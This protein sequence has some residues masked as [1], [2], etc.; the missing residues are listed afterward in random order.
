[1]SLRSWLLPVSWR[2][3]P[4][5]S[6]LAVACTVLAAVAVVRLLWFS[7]KTVPF[8]YPLEYVEGP[9][10]E[11][12]LTF[13]EFGDVYKTDFSR[14]PYVVALYPPLFT[15]L[16]VPL[17]WSFG[18]AFW[19]GR[20]ISLASAILAGLFVGLIIRTFTRSTPAALLGAAF[21][22]SFKSVAWWALISR[23]DVLAL[24]LSC[25]ALFVVARWR[26]EKQWLAVILLA[27]AIFTR[28]TYLLAAPLA[29]LNWLYM[30]RGPLV[31]MRFL[32]RLSIAVV[33]PFAGLMLWTKGAFWTHLISVHLTTPI[34]WSGVPPAILGG[35]G[36]LATL[37]TGG[38][39]VGCL[40]GVIRRRQ[41]HWH[42]VGPY[43]FGALVS[44]LAIGKVG[45]NSNYLLELAAAVSVICGLA[46]SSLTGNGGGPRTAWR[47]VVTLALLA[48]CGLVVQNRNP[49][50]D[51]TAVTLER[52]G[53]V[54]AVANLMA[55]TPGPV[56]ADW[57][58]GC[59]PQMG[60]HAYIEPFAFKQL[61]EAGKWDETPF[62]DA[63]GRREFG[64]ILLNQRLGR[65]EGN[66]TAAQLEAMHANYRVELTTFDTVVLVPK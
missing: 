21:F 65:P 45:S 25:A 46:L 61:S 47:S 7:H 51:L 34:V 54:A 26:E 20:A 66:W 17:V 29:A 1:M 12:A 39:L 3:T 31:A 32:G 37:L 62:V 16:Q 43:T 49:W 13:A 14:P 44:A 64:R 58:M 23:G 19:Y 53:E 63:I 48:L 55:A 8:P 28:Q 4:T 57:Y 9:I 10:L 6:F 24:C 50:H 11:Q 30:T 22:L 59:L 41:P 52:E 56:L 5:V 33:V 18:P 60:R 42:L 27:G 38:A 15:T 2:R 40:I 36:R 35:H